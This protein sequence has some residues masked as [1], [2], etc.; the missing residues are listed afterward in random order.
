MTPVADGVR[1]WQN[2]K[3]QLN[4]IRSY[5]VR[6]L[7]F[8]SVMALSAP[9]HA[10]TTAAPA[11]TPAPAPAAAATFDDEWT[12]EFPPFRLIGNVYWVGSWDLST[13]LITSPQGHILVNTGVGDTAARI[14]ARVEQLGFKMSDVRILT[15]T[16]AHV[17]HAAGLAE[18]K[19][20]TGAQ[21]WINE[22]DKDV[23]ESGGKTDFIFGARESMHFPVTKADRLFKDGD[24]I[25]VGNVALTA[26]LHAGHTKGATS[27]TFDV[28]ENGK[29]YRVIIAN[30]GSINP[31]VKVSGMPTYTSITKDYANTFMAQKELK[32]DVFLASHASQFKLHDKY[33]PGDAYDPDRFV[34]PD[35]YMSSVRTLEKTYQ[36][37]LA[38]ERAEKA[39]EKAPKAPAR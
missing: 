10:Q 37:Q 11:S 5:Q 20:M 19:K 18:L 8:A 6:A 21:I 35:L 7:A 23:F 39:A 36:D 31:G 2:R 29:T 17:D 25:T 32:I 24:K 12:R 22:R 3:M 1:L 30:M 34:D 16:H 4:A 15:A 26:H 28:P 9:L 13:Y 38:K 27:F 14:K 33:K